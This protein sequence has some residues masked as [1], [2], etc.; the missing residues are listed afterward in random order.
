MLRLRSR[1]GENV[2]SIGLVDFRWIKCSA[3]IDEREREPRVEVDDD[4]DDRIG[5]TCPRTGE[6][7][8]AL[9]CNAT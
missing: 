9:W 1:T 3:E 2:D 8:T 6:R 5:A 4:P 7:T